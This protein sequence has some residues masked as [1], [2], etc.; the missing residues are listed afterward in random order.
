[1][2]SCR[3]INLPAPMILCSIVELHIVRVFKTSPNW[4]YRFKTKFCSKL[5]MHMY[6]F[7][8]ENRFNFRFLWTTHLTGFLQLSVL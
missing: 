5:R 6:V 3:F 7:V 8:Y 4:S 2:L 1:M